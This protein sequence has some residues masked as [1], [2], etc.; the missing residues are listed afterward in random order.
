MRGFL[1]VAAL[2][3]GMAFADGALATGWT[4]ET[5]PPS[6]VELAAVQ[7]MLTTR[8]GNGAALWRQSNV[9]FAESITGGQ[10]IPV[11]AQPAFLRSYGRTTTAPAALSEIDVAF[12]GA[13]ASAMTAEERANPD[14]ISAER[15]A[16]LTQAAEPGVA[17]LTQE[18]HVAGLADGCRESRARAYLCAAMD[19][20]VGPSNRWMR[21]HSRR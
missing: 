3:A 1:K 10:V 18:I 5:S 2:V 6:A 11:E 15:L 9:R 4:Q 12:A 16:E 17:N 13:F 19:I 14:S 7:A 21:T 8:G 20:M